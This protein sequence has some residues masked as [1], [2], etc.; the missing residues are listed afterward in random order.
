MASKTAGGQADC[1]CPYETEAVRLLAAFRGVKQWLPRH[2]YLMQRPSRP[3]KNNPAAPRGTL[4]RRQKST[5]TARGLFFHRRKGSPPA[6]AALRHRPQTLHRPSA[7][8]R[9]PARPLPVRGNNCRRIRNPRP[10]LGAS[11]QDR[12]QAND[13]GVQIF[14]MRLSHLHEDGFAPG[15]GAGCETAR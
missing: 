10:R 3:G 1:T 11:A 4:Y 12:G 8:S 9:R 7:A 6:R 13:M 14:T 2:R 5:V 15:G